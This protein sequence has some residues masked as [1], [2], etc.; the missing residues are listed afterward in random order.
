MAF[1]CCGASSL[2]KEYTAE[3]P[4]WPDDMPA[5]PKTPS[6]SAS[7]AKAVVT[8]EKIWQTSSS[9]QEKEKPPLVTPPN[10]LED[11]SD[12]KSTLANVAR[13]TFALWGIAAVVAGA[14]AVIN[15]LEDR[16]RE[17]TETKSDKLTRVRAAEAARRERLAARSKGK[18]AEQL[19][20]QAAQAAADAKSKA[21]V[22]D[23]GKQVRRR[24]QVYSVEVALEGRSTQD[25]TS[26]LSAP[27]AF[28]VEELPSPKDS[29]L[30][31]Q[32]R[33]GKASSKDDNCSLVQ[34]ASFSNKDAAKSYAKS[35]KDSHGLKASIYAKT[36]D[37]A[38]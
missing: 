15:F 36:T 17:A 11:E 21:E 20:K 10:L 25:V 9:P 2:P 13:M 22:N 29:R 30:P 23:S 12:G 38:S 14:Q 7:P 34:V 28:C 3:P 37:V 1:L 5:K 18:N 4:Q 19:A 16:N 8:P 6:P 31:F 33:G 35:L 24:M 27:G 32:K 26:K